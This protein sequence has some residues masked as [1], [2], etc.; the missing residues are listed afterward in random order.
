MGLT[1]RRLSS[2]V[3]LRRQAVL[4]IARAAQPLLRLVIS[5]AISSRKIVALDP[6]HVGKTIV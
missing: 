4:A 1:G 5:E 2:G 3:L 6:G